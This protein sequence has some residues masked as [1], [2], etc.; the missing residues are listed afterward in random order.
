MHGLAQLTAGPPD[1]EGPLADEAAVDVALEEVEDGGL[2]EDGELGVELA[3]D[4]R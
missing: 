2:G 3:A 4:G 1:E